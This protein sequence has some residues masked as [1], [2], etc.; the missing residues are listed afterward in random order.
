[1]EG[2]N[3]LVGLFEMLPTLQRFEEIDAWKKA[4]VLTRRVYAVTGHGDFARDLGLRNQIQRAAVLVMSNIVEEF[5]RGSRREFARFL[6]I[7]KASAGEVRSQLYVAFDI[8]YLNEST[9]AD[10]KE[11]CEEVSR[12]ISGLIR[13]L[14]NSG[15]APAN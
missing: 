10:L 11:Q 12:L 15:K 7:A 5:E 1:M 8:G 4:R 9:F 14:R 3:L 13:Y 2:R 6:S